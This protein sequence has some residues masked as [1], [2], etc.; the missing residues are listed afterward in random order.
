MP[1]F[2]LLLPMLFQIGLALLCHRKECSDAFS[3]A[4]GW[5]ICEGSFCYILRLQNVTNSGHFLLRRGC[6]GSE[7]PQIRYNNEL[8]PFTSLNECRKILWKDI[9]YL[10]GICAD[11]DF[12]NVCNYW[13]E[14]AAEKSAADGIMRAGGENNLRGKK[15]LMGTA[16]LLPLLAFYFIDKMI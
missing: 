2:A 7:S 9:E 15:L 11:S 10:L 6:F 14:L 12:C 4:F 13:S 1:S 8:K 3:C 16:A 5:D